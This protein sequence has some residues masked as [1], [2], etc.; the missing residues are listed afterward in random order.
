MV[1][2]V[3]FGCDVRRLDHGGGQVQ[4]TVTAHDDGLLDGAVT[5]PGMD[6]PQL[7]ASSGGCVVESEWTPGARVRPEH[8]DL[9]LLHGLM[10]QDMDYARPVDTV[11]L[12]VCVDGQDLGLEEAGVVVSLEVPDAEYGETWSGDQVAGVMFGVYVWSRDDLELRL[13]QAPIAADGDL[14]GATLTLDD[15]LTGSLTDATRTLTW[16]VD[17]LTGAPCTDCQE[18]VTVEL[19]WA[20]DPDVSLQR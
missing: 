9:D 3:L 8:D 4:V 18:Q 12:V 17:P 6:V 10:F 20:F 14:E 7:R 2:L 13:G 16:D 11:Q 1:L 19:D 5:V 15:E